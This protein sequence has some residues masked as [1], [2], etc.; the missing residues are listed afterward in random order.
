MVDGCWAGRGTHVEE[1]TDIGFEH[2]SEGTEEPA[3]RVDFLLV[4]FF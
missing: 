3:M 2:G 4:L 1:D